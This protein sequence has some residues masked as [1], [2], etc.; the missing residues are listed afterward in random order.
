MNP[1]ARSNLKF[2]AIVAVLITASVFLYGRARSLWTTGESGASVWF[3]DQSEKRLY[4]VPSGT[5][6][7]HKGIGGQSGD[8][9]R[10]VVVT[11]GGNRG[12]SPEQRIAYLETYAPELKQILEQVRAARDAHQPFKGPIPSR[13]SDFFQ[14]NTM[15]KRP[16]DASWFPSNGSEGQRVISEWRDWRGPYGEPPAISVP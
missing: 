13:D 9:V 11:F 7:P 5:I 6:A 12:Q 2:L 3:Y 16:E 4:P 10:A 15:V 1:A 8:G 14:T